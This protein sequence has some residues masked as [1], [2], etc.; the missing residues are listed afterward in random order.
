[1]DPHEPEALADDFPAQPARARRGVSLIFVSLLVIGLTGIAYLHPSIGASP[2]HVAPTVPAAYQLAAVDFVTPDTGWFAGT[3]DSGRFALMHTTDAGDHW[4]RQLSG[5]VG[6]AGV[7][8]N[9]FDSTGG[10]VAVLGPQSVIYRTADGGHRW[11]VSPILS[12]V[13]YLTSVSSV[14][15]ADAS[16]GWLL[17]S[18]PTVASGA[19][20][21]RTNDGGLTWTNLGSPA[22]GNDLVYRVHFTDPQTGWLDSLSAGPYAYKSADGGATWRQVPLPAPRGGWSAAG[23]FL[24]SAQPTQGSGVV[25]TVASFAPTLGRSGIGAAVVSYPPLTVRAFDGGAS[26][27][28]VYLTLA[29]T[30]S[31]SP[32]SAADTKSRS[33]SSAQVQAPNQVQLGSLD[34]G[35]TWTAIA[36]PTAPGAIGYFNAR[37]WWW[38]GSGAWST[39]SDGGTT[40]TPNR[41]LGV[42]QPLPGSLQ[43]LDPTHAWFG[44]MTGARAVLED[45]SD[46]GLHWQMTVLPV[47]RPS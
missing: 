23:Q 44:A 22:L 37:D 5:D 18:T 38:I 43:V 28:Y 34:G 6:N 31:S 29:D 47:L 19:E 40:W 42:P 27:S 10:V 46:G 16:H 20:L 39:S 21:L 24:V 15:F 9:F 12:G 35:S 26:V 17:L 2:S 8:V 11:S 36:P 32:W 25:A 13:A 7:Y 4:A 3:F 33:G 41:N 1:M 30:L 14:S 45:T